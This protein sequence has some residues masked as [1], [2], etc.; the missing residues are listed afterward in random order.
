MK[1]DLDV[2]SCIVLPLVG[3][4]SMREMKKRAK[5]SIEL[6]IF[7]EG[8]YRLKPVYGER[9]LTLAR[10]YARAGTMIFVFSVILPFFFAL[11]K[12]LH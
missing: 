8:I 1:L 12:Y 3:Y 11:I 2:I 6:K 5:R 10:G 7:S 4:I 9:A